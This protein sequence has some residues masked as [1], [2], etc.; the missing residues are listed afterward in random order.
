M[1]LA[2]E[3]RLGRWI[4]QR[5]N[6]FSKGL[7]VTDIVNDNLQILMRDLQEVKDPSADT[8]AIAL[9]HLNI[10]LANEITKGY[11]NI[12]TYKLRPELQ[13][14]L[15]AAD[16]VFIV[17]QTFTPTAIAEAVKANGLPFHASGTGDK[18]DENL[19][20]ERIH[21]A[22]NVHHVSQLQAF[23]VKGVCDDLHAVKL[24]PREYCTC[25]RK[26]TCCHIIAVKLSLGLGQTVVRSKG[27]PAPCIVVNVTQP[28]T[29]F[30]QQTGAVQ[31]NSAA[32]TIAN[33][34]ASGAAAAAEAGGQQIF[35]L[36][37]FIEALTVARECIV[38]PANATGGTVTQASA[39]ITGV[40]SQ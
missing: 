12:G 15:R 31:A 25:L 11:C 6:L 39:T 17:E 29:V 7:G 38:S 28:S 2:I 3:T 4:L 32:Q 1:R 33:L 13:Y 35:T 5:Y 19:R 20:G 37:S 14:M 26:D 24:Y 23:L 27:T 30:Q 36:D 9:Y 16:E 10:F 40:G 22:G 34:V 8:I 18:L 21:S